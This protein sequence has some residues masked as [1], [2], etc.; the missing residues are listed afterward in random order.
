MSCLELKIGLE[1]E[2]L[3]KFYTF[4]AEQKAK[5]EF[6]LV[7]ETDLKNKAKTDEL[8]GAERISVKET[9]AGKEETGGDCN[10]QS[11]GVEAFKN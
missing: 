3:F 5:L 11:F 6:E 9:E 2:K 1:Y 10:N 4:E 8:N 7:K